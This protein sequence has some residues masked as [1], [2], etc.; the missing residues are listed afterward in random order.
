MKSCGEIVILQ[1]RGY[2]KYFVYWMKVIFSHIAMWINFKGSYKD[3]Y[4][5]R[6]LLVIEVLLHHFFKLRS[7]MAFALATFFY[8][9]GEKFKSLEL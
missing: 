3:T 9:L 7:T 2:H 6:A 8:M 5:K 1:N 4:Y